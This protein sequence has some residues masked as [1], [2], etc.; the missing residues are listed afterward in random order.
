ME[1]TMKLQEWREKK[2]LSL[3]GAAQAMGFPITA[4]AK[5][6][7]WENGAIP[8]PEHMKIIMTTTNNWV[9]IN[10]FYT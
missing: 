2:K 3:A 10:D 7:R 4:A 5:I 1:L 8:S 9:K 6:Y